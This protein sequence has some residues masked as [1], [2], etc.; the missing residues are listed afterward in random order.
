MR[1]PYK[2]KATINQY[3]AFRSDN[4]GFLDAETK[5]RCLK[6]INVAAQEHQF[7]FELAPG[8]ILVFSRLGKTIRITGP[9]WL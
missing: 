3:Y 7:S 4:G 8:N 9:V 2:L 6:A 1:I 5:V